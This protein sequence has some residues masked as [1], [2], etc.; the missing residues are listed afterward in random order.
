MGRK[1][2]NVGRLHSSP[3]C[4]PLVAGTGAACLGYWNQISTHGSVLSGAAVPHQWH[5]RAACQVEGRTYESL[6][7]LS[8]LIYKI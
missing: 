6:T 5:W 7:K 8:F 3:F 1:E 2:D 4:L